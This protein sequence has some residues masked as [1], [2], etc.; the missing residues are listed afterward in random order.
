VVS[1]SVEQRRSEMG[2]RMALGATGPGL[3][4]MV[5]TESLGPVAV[6][7]AGGLLGTL[8]LEQILRGLL[9]GVG[10]AD[11]P[12]V[13]GVMLVVLTIAGV[14]CYVPASRITKANPVTWLRWEQ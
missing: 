4:R 5:V 14:A 3:R 8:A 1:Y 6:G 13:A 10:V 12:T 7:L 9:F 11:P 2:I